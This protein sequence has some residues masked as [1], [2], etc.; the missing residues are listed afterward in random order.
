MKWKDIENRPDN[1]KITEESSTA[2][3]GSSLGWLLQLDGDNL[4][5]AF[6]NAPWV[7]AVLPIRPG[8]EKAALNWLRAIVGSDKDGWDTPYL[9]N[10]DPE[11]QEKTIGEVLEIIAER[12][13]VQNGDIQNTLQAD[14]VFEHGF[15]HLAGGFDAGLPAN[16]VFSQWISVLPT[17][18]IVAVEYKATDLFTPNV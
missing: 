10:D 16:K 12:V 5:N 4:R 1:Y 14:K 3:L 2:K 11:F 13:E 18:Q 6:L 7:K 8:R 17:D 15:N 9:G